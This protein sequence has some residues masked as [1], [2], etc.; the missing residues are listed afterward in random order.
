IDTTDFT[1]YL[2]LYNSIAFSPAPYDLVYPKTIVQKFEFGGIFSNRN[3]ENSS[4]YSFCDTVPTQVP[5]I[6]ASSSNLIS[7]NNDHFS[8]RF[9]NVQPTY[10]KTEWV[11]GKIT[12]RIFSS[13]DATDQYPLS[14]LNQQKSILLKG[15]D[16]SGLKL[17]QFSFENVEGFDYADYFNYVF[18]PESLKKKLVKS[19]V[20]YGKAF[21]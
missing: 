15:L 6:D 17:Q 5:Y 10:Y 20:G 9:N 14:F 13:S 3:Y 19:S 8:V 1:K 18:N 21:Q 4:Y 2:W 11:S 16:L 7:T 12:F